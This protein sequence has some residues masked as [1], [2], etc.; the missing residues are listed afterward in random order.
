MVRRTSNSEGRCPTHPKSLGVCPSVVRQSYESRLGPVDQSG[1]S[2]LLSTIRVDPSGVGPSRVGPAILSGQVV[3]YMLTC[4]LCVE[5]EI[6]LILGCT[7]FSPPGAI[8]SVLF[9]NYCVG[10][11]CPRRSRSPDSTAHGIK[12]L[13]H[14]RNEQKRSLL[15]YYDTSSSSSRP[16]DL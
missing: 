12:A 15:T 2:S 6:E 7:F 8:L 1:G 3:R 13:P 10:T 5:S 4:T 11:T 14:E 9:W 16:S